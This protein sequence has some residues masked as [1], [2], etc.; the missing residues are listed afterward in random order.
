MLG[1]TFDSTIKGCIPQLICVGGCAAC[2][3]GYILSDGL[4]KTC[5]GTGCR[6]CLSTALN[7]CTSC[8]SG[9]FLNSARSACRLCPSSCTTC[10]SSSVCTSCASGYTSTATSLVGAG[11]KCLKCSPRCA[12]C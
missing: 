8:V 7:N 5:T 11:F 9:F 4:C 1:Y 2:P 10:L 3:F 6:T 12:T